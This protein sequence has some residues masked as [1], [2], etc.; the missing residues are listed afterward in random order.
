[1]AVRKDLWPEM[2]V[3]QLRRL[4]GEG[5]FSLAEMGMKLGVGRCAVAMKMRR[6]GLENRRARP[7]RRQEK[8]PQQPKTPI[9]Q[10]KNLPP[11]IRADG[12]QVTL[13][14]V[15]EGECR[16]PYGEGHGG[17]LVLCGRK[18]RA[19]SPYCEA[20]RRIAFKLVQTKGGGA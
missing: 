8:A 19:G 11:I 13:A 1:M 20:H 2:R 14:N 4:A 17:E 7:K 6:L 12:S 9:P 16:F 15:G 10:S 18:T 3:A 5:R